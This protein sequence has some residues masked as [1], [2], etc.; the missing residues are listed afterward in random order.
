MN[1]IAKVVLFIIFLSCFF[2]EE[3]KKTKQ[4]RATAHKTT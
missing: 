3:E 1:A 2:V 4:N